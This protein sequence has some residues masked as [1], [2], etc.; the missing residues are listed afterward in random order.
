MSS[1]AQAPNAA[2]R[3]GHPL[4]VLFSLVS[5]ER[6]RVVRAIASSII[7]KIFDVM[8]EILIGIALDIV[9]RGRD[10]FVA[11]LGITDP[12]QQLTLLGIATFFIWFGESLFEYFYQILW[13]GLAQEIQHR[14][15]ILCYDHAQHLP[16]GFYEENRSGELVTILNDDI[17]QLERFLDRGANELIQTF[18]AVILVGAVFFIV[19]P[20]I[21]VIAF[22]P[23]PAIVAGA[24]WFQRRAQARYDAVRAR[25]GNLG[26]RLTTNLQGLQTI[27]A[28]GA[29]ARETATLTRESLAYVE[30]NRAAIRVSSAF[31]PIIRM[32]I[33]SGFLATFLIGGWLTLTGQ[34]QV[35]AY[36]LLVFLTQRLLWPMTGLAEIADLYERAMASTRRILRL[37]DEPRGEPHGRHEAR[38]SGSFRIEDISFR[39]ATGPGGVSGIDL[40]IRAGETVALV[41]P[42]GSGKSTLIKLLGLFIRPQKGRILLDG[43]PLGDWSGE[44]LRKSMAWVPQEV[45][46]FHGTVAENIAYGRP[47]AS[48][49]EIEAAARF[50]EADGFIRALPHGYDS[51]I[52]EYG[53]KLSGGQRQRIALARALLIDPAILILDEAT[54][55]VDN[56]TEA[57]IQRSLAKM[58][59]KRTV[60]LVAHRLST[61]VHADAIHVM[62]DGRIIQ[63]GTH[64]ALVAGRGLYRTLWDI[65]TGHAPSDATA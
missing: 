54:S 58:K 34:M 33:L 46:L 16:T 29:E 1:P 51:P 39:Y 2:A 44:C 37:L 53:Q 19:S 30:A 9:V 22:T 6:G 21:A 15:R 25:A 62:E 38:V 13:R 23:V 57:A 48:R 52:G 5:D 27:R 45:T 63:S 41:G 32:A 4:L 14:L 50:A 24:F 10:S 17:N 59:G 28:F 7:N 26:A 35:G 61:V 11:Q 18:A 49:G 36:G 47:A 40:S 8:P 64:D 60:I 56:E 42:T 65:Q 3:P 31:I 43:V 55:A 12:V 20:L